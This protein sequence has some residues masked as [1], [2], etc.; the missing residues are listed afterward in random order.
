MKLKL[1]IYLRHVPCFEQA[2][3]GWCALDERCHDVHTGWGNVGLCVGLCPCTSLMYDVS[4]C[5]ESSEI[6]EQN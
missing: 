3:F 2:R 1:Y 5:I 6:V 4:D